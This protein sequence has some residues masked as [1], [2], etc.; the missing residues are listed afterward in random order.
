MSGTA[1]PSHTLIE[2]SF[3][4]RVAN[5]THRTEFDRLVDSVRAIGAELAPVGARG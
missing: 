2:G 3:V 4:I 5:L 1:V